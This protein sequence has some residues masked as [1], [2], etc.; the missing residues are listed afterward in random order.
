MDISEA[1]IQSEIGQLK[2]ALA[3][4]MEEDKASGLALDVISFERLEDLLKALADA[5]AIALV[6]TSQDQTKLLSSVDA[7]DSFLE[8]QYAIVQAANSRLQVCATPS[9][10]DTRQATGG[11]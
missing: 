6:G 2:H 3:K 8:D 5:R 11:D 9:R 7:F 1:E 4:S 10:G